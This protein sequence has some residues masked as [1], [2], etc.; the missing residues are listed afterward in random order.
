[1]KNVDWKDVLNRAGKTFAQAAMSCLI[2]SLSGVNF[3]TG[4]K[5]DTFWIGLALSAM[6]AGLSAVWNGIVQP[7]IT[8]ANSTTDSQ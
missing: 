7:L 5:S 4:A 6:A 1:M 3:T 8:A 2:A